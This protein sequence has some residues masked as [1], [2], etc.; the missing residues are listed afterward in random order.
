MRESI[1]KDLSSEKQR[2]AKQSKTK[3]TTTIPELR[4]YLY[5]HARSS[6]SFLARGQESLQKKTK[7]ITSY[8]LVQI[9]TLDKDW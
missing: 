4:K 8:Q 9:E 5:A 1:V 6:R 3:A 7:R 2:E